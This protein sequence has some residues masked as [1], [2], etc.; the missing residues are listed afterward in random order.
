[1][2]DEQQE[3]VIAPEPLAVIGE[4]HLE[5]ESGQHQVPD[6]FVRSPFRDREEQEAAVSGHPADEVSAK[7]SVA[8]RGT[9]LHAAPGSPP[10]GVLPLPSIEESEGVL[11]DSGPQPFEFQRRWLLA[12][13]LLMMLCCCGW[14]GGLLFGWYGYPVEWDATEW[15]GA[16]VYNLNA[17]DRERY[18][19]NLADLH[20]FDNNDA[21]VHAA[22]EGERMLSDTC[23]L[24]SHRLADGKAAEGARLFM[25]S[26]LMGG[27]ALLQSE[28]GVDGIQSAP[29]G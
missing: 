29:A 23:L 12:L 22:L 11:M 6:E 3:Q 15:R 16:E 4:E 25:L 18:L 2:S 8:A 10:P 5:E 1:M 26:E 7:E 13:P 24:M 28:G 19:Q 14:A 21:R 27:C 20:S 9:E 17:G